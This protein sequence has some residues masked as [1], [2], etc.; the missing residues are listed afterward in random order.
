MIWRFKYHE[1]KWKLIVYC[2][3]SK[4]KGRI[5]TIE[6]LVES[7]PLEDDIRRFDSYKNLIKGLSHLDFTCGRGGFIQLSGQVSKKPV[8]WSLIK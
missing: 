3:S 4:F 8:V 7:Q 1:I 2:Y 6:G 5:K